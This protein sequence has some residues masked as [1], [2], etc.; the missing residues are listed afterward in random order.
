VPPRLFALELM[1]AA[2]PRTFEELPLE[3]KSVLAIGPGL[4]LAPGLVAAAVQ[5][6]A[7]PVVLDADA[8]NSLEAPDWRAGGTLCVITP[9]P[10]EM[11]RLVRTTVA[12]VQ[13]DHGCA[14]QSTMRW[15][16]A[17]LLC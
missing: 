14:W 4:G 2:L 5:R 7:V 8:L 3:R 10:G 15:T 11:A 17:A 6:A 16:T 13:R 9:H 12:D 1:T